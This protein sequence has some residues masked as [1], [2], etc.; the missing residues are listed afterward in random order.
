MTASFLS[1]QEK[2]AATN[3]LLKDA[4]DELE[5]KLDVRGAFRKLTT[6]TTLVW[7]AMEFCIGVPL[8]SVSNFLPQ[9]VARLVSWM[10]NWH[11]QLYSSIIITDRGTPLFTQIS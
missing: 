9:I 8:A 5:S 4:S 11:N 1:E 10:S 2:E 3:R 6:W 7:V